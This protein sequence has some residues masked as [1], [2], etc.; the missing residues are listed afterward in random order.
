MVKESI[1]TQAPR[2][3]TRRMMKEYI[4]CSLSPVCR[5]RL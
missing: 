4:D 3:S 5:A 2:F 1:K